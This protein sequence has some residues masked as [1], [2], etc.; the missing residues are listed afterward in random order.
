MT[1]RPPQ[2][3]GKCH[4]VAERHSEHS[5]SVF[6]AFH[7]VFCGFI[8]FCY[9]SFHDAVMTKRY[10]KIPNPRKLYILVCVSSGLL[11]WGTLRDPETM[12]YGLVSTQLG[13]KTLP[14]SL[15]CL[16]ATLWHLPR[17]CTDLGVDYI[18]LYK[19]YNVI[20]IFVTV[21]KDL[22]KS[23]FIYIL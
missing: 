6:G 21:I 17:R 4:S 22:I 11:A 20:L 18:P 19:I 16:S 5:E 13:S 23:A 2:R 12:R 7:S 1:P 9:L 14:D 15:L 3:L 10:F 8:T